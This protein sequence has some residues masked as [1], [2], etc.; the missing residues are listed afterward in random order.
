M[1]ELE[2]VSERADYLNSIYVA[3]LAQEENKEKS[4]GA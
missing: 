1:E 4:C 2:K 3:N